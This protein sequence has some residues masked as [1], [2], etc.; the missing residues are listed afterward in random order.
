MFSDSVAKGFRLVTI[1]IVIYEFLTV[2]NE[3]LREEKDERRRRLFAILMDRFPQ[4]LRDLEIEVEC[5]KL[6]SDDV[7]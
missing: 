2:I 5:I 4:L 7:E 1:P 3:L 6:S